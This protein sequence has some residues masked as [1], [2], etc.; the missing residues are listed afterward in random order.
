MKAAKKTRARGP[1]ATKIEAQFWRVQQTALALNKCDPAEVFE[2]VRRLSR[3]AIV[4]LAQALSEER[5]AARPFAKM[6]VPMSAITGDAAELT[7]PRRALWVDRAQ[8]LVACLCTATAPEDGCPLHD[9]GGA[10]L[11]AG[12]R[13]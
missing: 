8:R 12:A 6:I 2:I 7:P 9:V 11:G 3:E 5:S 10:T 4:N 13:D 1:A